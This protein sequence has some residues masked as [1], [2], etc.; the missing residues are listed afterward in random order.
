MLSELNSK[1]LM[2]ENLT[3][4]C[5]TV[6]NLFT[7]CT[8]D[9]ENLPKSVYGILITIIRDANVSVQIFFDTSSINKCTYIR[10]KNIGVWDSWNRIQ[11][12]AL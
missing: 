5:D 6:A 1:T 2:K 7:F 12:V 11:F 3:V 10:T 9:S 8:S 4:N